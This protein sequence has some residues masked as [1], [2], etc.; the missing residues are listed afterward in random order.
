MASGRLELLYN[1]APGMDCP[2]PSAECEYCFSN[3]LQQWVSVRTLVRK[4][5][6]TLRHTTEI[7]EKVTDCLC[8]NAAQTTVVLQDAFK[9]VIFF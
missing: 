7:E 6:I 4:S 5:T 2:D 9:E 8:A 1:S 3:S